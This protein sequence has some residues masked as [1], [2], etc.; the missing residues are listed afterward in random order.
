MVPY[1][2]D[3]VYDSDAYVRTSMWVDFKEETKAGTGRFKGATDPCIVD[4]QSE[5]LLPTEVRVKEAVV[6][7]GLR[8]TLN[9]R[10]FTVVFDE[11]FWREVVEWAATYTA[12]REERELPPTDPEYGWECQLCDYRYRFGQSDEPYEAVGPTGFLPQFD[13]YPR[14]RVVEYLRAHETAQLPP[15][16]VRASPDLAEQYGVHSWSRPDC[17]RCFEWGAV[18]PPEETSDSPICPCCAE[19]GVLATLR[20]PQPV[21]EG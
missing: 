7:Y 21:D 8:E 2:R 15:T 1:L 12:Y 10:A 16:L 14:E 5:P 11:A 4:R 3:V 9:L 19:E 17:R 20:S 13:T 18:E 6:V